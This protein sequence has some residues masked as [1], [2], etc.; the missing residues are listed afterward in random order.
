MFRIIG[1][2]N[3]EILS[4]LL[5]KCGYLM[6][7]TQVMYNGHTGLP[8]QQ[9]VF[10]GIAKYQRLRHNVDDKIQARSRGPK[11]LLERQPTHGK[12]FLRSFTPDKAKNS[13]TWLFRI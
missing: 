7:G 13:I 1:K 3:A 6:N 12:W 5:H 2:S 9:K 8:L 4:N 11:T 10:I